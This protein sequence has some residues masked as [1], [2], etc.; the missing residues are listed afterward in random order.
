LRK[1]FL[2][3][4]K[5]FY[6]IV[7][8][9]KSHKGFLSSGQSSLTTLSA[10]LTMSRANADFGGTRR[11]PRLKNAFSVFKLTSYKTP[12]AAPP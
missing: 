1:L 4:F 8:Q 5:L 9:F 7:S 11:I 10:R 12:E 2:L 6:Y 3:V